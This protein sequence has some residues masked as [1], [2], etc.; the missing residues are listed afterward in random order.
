SHY[1]ETHSRPLQAYALGMIDRWARLASVAPRLANFANNAPGVRQI[2]GSALHLAPER[3]LPRFAP[4][5]FR[6]WAHHWRL[7]DAAMAG[8][9]SNRSRQVILWADTFNTTFIR[10][11][12]KPRTKC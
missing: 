7:P 1:Y 6:Q 8:G 10:R 2:L 4:H 9:T 11:P 3:Q 5:T 12:A